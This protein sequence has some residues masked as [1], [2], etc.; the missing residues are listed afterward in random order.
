M[1]L[2]DAHMG[3]RSSPRDGNDLLPISEWPSFTAH[4]HA[5]GKNKALS[6]LTVITASRAIVVYY[7][8]PLKRWPSLWACRSKPIQP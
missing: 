1:P 5:N 6:P 7:T 2:S 4:F 3:P 8:P